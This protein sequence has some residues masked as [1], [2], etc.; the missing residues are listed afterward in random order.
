[1]KRAAFLVL[2]LL[3][4]RSSALAQSA[5]PPPTKPAVAESASQGNDVV[6]GVVSAQGADP[7]LRERCEIRIG[8]GQSNATG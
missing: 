5:T 1:M 7:R 3:A 8:H 2:A 6:A 4:A